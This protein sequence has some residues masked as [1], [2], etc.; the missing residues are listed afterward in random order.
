MAIG[1]ANKAIERELHHLKRET[2]AQIGFATLA[3][4]FGILHLVLFLF[5]PNLKSNLYFA[6]TVFLYAMNIYFDYQ[7]F[8]AT[9]LVDSL[10]Y[11]RIHRSVMPGSNIFAMLFIY[12][13][14]TIKIPRHFWLIALGLIVTGGLAVYKPLENFDYIQI[15]MVATFIE[16]VRIL[17]QAIRQRKEG[18][19]IIAIGFVGLFIFSSYDMLLDLDIMSPIYDINNGYPFGFVILIISMSIYLARD[20]SKT[21]EKILTQERL[22]KEREIERRL[23]EADNSRK[24]KE[25]E[26]ARQLQLSMLPQ[27]ITSIPGV[28]I[29]FHMQTATEV[30]GDYYDYFIS[31]DRTFTIAIGDATGHG[32]KA[33]IM[34]AVIK[35]MFVALADKMD[36]LTFLQ[37]CSLTIRQMHLGNLYM[38]MSLVKLKD[39][40]M[41]VSSAGMPPIYIYRNQTQSVEELI[42][43]ALP[44]GATASFSTEEKILKLETGDTVLLLSDGYIELFNDQDEILDYPRLIQ[45]FQQ[46]GEQS[47]DDIVAHLIKRGDQ[48]RKVRPQTDDI[49]FVVIKVKGEGNSN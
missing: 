15:F 14:F 41:T 2:T 17:I 40:K 38:G 39:K 23:L 8:L 22:A 24:S 31:E 6:I 11:L 46:V 10:F 7:N 16:M 47:P 34:V 12:S 30:G 45:Y 1:E 19:W 37:K 9:N 35:S 25:L 4:A 27:C 18:A 20:F 44:L 21:N 43:K 29:C 3:I 36:T 32:I 48:W 49:T 42:I 5:Y 28:D 33:G 26:E 13:I